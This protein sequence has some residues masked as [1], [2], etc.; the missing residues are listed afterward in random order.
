MI[1]SDKRLREKVGGLRPGVVDRLG[2]AQAL[3]LRRLH[4]LI[5]LASLDMGRGQRRQVVGQ[6]RQIVQLTP[7]LAG[8]LKRRPGLSCAAGPLVGTRYVVQSKG[9]LLPQVVLS[10]YGQ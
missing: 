8:F 2:D 6:H 5:E 7:Q 10:G 3:L 9:E 1:R 4:R